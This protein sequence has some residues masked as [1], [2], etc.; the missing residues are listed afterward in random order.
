[1]R[2]RFRRSI[3][4]YKWTQLIDRPRRDAFHLGK[5]IYGRV[6]PVRD[7]LFGA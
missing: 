5:L 1:M 2:S 3:G 4:F 7:Y 6:R